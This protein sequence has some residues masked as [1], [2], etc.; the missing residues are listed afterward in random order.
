MKATVSPADG[1][2]QRCHVGRVEERVGWVLGEKRIWRDKWAA[3]G[4]PSTAPA[5]W[6]LGRCSLFLFPLP[7]AENK[8]KST[9]IKEG[10][11]RDIRI[12]LRCWNYALIEIIGLGIFRER[13]L[14]QV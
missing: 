13:K 3:A 2:V 1:W 11:M 6:K 5:C 7:Q 14:S 9:G 8:Q 4:L 12:S 10:C